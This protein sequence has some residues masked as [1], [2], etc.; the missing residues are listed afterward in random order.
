VPSRERRGP[1]LPDYALWKITVLNALLMIVV[2]AAAGQDMYLD[3]AIDAHTVRVTA[4][5]LDFTEQGR[6]SSDYYTVR[7]TYEEQSL[8]V[9]LDSLNGDPAVFDQVCLEINAEEPRDARACGTHTQPMV[10]LGFLASLGLLE[11]ALVATLARRRRRERD[12]Q[13]SEQDLQ[14]REQDPWSSERLAAEIRR[15]L[16]AGELPVNPNLPGV[17]YLVQRHRADARTV[18]KA[19]AALVGERVLKRKPVSGPPV[20]FIRPLTD[21]RPPGPATSTVTGTGGSG[22]GRS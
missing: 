18:E 17:G 20:Y 10:L 4:T 16:A 7:Y 1:W 15:E 12:L 22:A 21:W 11:L 5:V 3:R 9:E 2:T 19:L 14:P 6:L 13:A 8:V